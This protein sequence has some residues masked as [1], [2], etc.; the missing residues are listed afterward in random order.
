MALDGEHGSDEQLGADDSVRHGRGKRTQ[1]H[2]LRADPCRDGR[3]ALEQREAEDWCARDGGIQKGGVELEEARCRIADGELA[4]RPA[5][6][7]RQSIVVHGCRACRVERGEH[8]GVGQREPELGVPHKGHRGEARG[9][10]EHED[11]AD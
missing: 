5:A 9:V 8:A 7:M 3:R 4:A 1:Q 6:H 11:G 10:A 2:G